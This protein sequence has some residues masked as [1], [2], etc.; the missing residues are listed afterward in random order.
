MM[1]VD[2]RINMGSTIW[3]T[4][5]KCHTKSFQEFSKGGFISMARAHSSTVEALLR[6]YLVTHNSYRGARS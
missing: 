4:K 1:K 5:N 3:N 6:T 2:A